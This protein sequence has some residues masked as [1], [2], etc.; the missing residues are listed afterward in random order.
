LADVNSKEETLYEPTDP[1]QLGRKIMEFD[2]KGQKLT[3]LEL[4]L[5][6]IIFIKM[7]RCIDD[8][9]NSMLSINFI[10]DTARFEDKSMLKVK[11]P[12]GSFKA[13]LVSNLYKNFESD[14]DIAPVYQYTKQNRGS[15]RGKVRNRDQF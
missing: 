7:H 3:K 2:Q 11:R 6:W 9:K 15:G 8:G 13:N 14:S 5:T 4:I 1:D 10:C 12:K